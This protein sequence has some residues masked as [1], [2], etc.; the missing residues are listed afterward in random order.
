MLRIFQ[1]RFRSL[2]GDILGGHREL[3]LDRPKAKEASDDAAA[4][5]HATADLHSKAAL[6]YGGALT[7]VQVISTLFVITYQTLT[8]KSF[9]SFHV[10]AATV[11]VLALVQTES[12]SLPWINLRATVGATG[13]QAGLTVVFLADQARQALDA[14]AR[15][16]TRL[17]VTRRHLL[18]GRRVSFQHCYHRPLRQGRRPLLPFHLGNGEHR[19]VHFLGR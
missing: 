19:N 16:L 1:S 4:A 3:L 18:D 11:V 9:E 17:F 5:E 14:V 6:V 12:W 10:T 2:V 15:T 13:A 7:L 8:S